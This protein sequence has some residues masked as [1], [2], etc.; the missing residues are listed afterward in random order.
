MRAH[1]A[2]KAKGRYICPIAGGVFTRGLGYS[3]ELAEPMRLVF[4]PG[5]DNN[6]YEPDP[7]RPGWNRPVTYQRAEPDASEQGYLDRAAGRVFGP[8]CVISRG[9]SPPPADDGRH[10]RAGVYLVPAPEAD[11][12]T[13]FVNQPVT[14]KSARPARPR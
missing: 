7:D 6:R 13:W 9:F 4:Q 14:Y 1:T 2:G 10:G 11:P 8:G 3:V 12:A 5:W